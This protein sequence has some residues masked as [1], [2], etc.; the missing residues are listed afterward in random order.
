MYT[1]RICCIRRLFGLGVSQQCVLVAQKANR[2][3]RCMKRIAASRAREVVLSQYSA[4]VRPHLQH[5]IQMW[6]PRYTRDGAVVA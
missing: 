5:C 6:S 4:L 3:L 2:A 1:G